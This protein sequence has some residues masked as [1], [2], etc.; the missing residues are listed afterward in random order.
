MACIGGCLMG[1][2]R[3]DEYLGGYV[4][5]DIENGRRCLMLYCMPENIC[6][7]QNL[8]MDIG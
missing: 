1:S 2:A 3:E 4:L 7:D 8:M 6:W 5:L